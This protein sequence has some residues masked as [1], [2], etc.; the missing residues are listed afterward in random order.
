[1]VQQEITTPSMTNHCQLKM[2]SRVFY[3]F[4]LHT[5]L[6]SLL[7]SNNDSGMLVAVC[8]DADAVIGNYNSISSGAVVVTGST[9]CSNARLVPYNGKLN[10]GTVMVLHDGVWGTI[11][12]GYWDIEDA[13]VFCNQLGMGDAVSNGNYYSPSYGTQWYGFDCDGTESSLQDCRQVYGNWEIYRRGSQ[14][15]P[16]YGA[17][18]VCSHVQY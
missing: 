6:F 4:L 13:Q 5:A 15:N 1:M 18:V 9:Q 7:L 12:S 14:N 17:G 10:E 2:L 8:A 11:Y 16:N 3:S